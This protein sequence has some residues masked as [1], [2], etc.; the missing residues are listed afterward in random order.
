MAYD[1]AAFDGWQSQ[2]SGRT[3]QDHLEAAIS[4]VT[5]QRIRTHAAGRT[6]TGVHALGQA[7]H[8]DVPELMSADKWIAALNGNLP[9]TIRVVRSRQV[10]T[11]FHAR[12]SSLG[13][14]YRYRIWNS[15]WMHPLELGRA[16][17]VAGTVDMATLSAVTQK[18][19][20]HHDFHAFSANRGGPPENS[21]RTL[22]AIRLRK[23]GPLITLEIDGDGFLYKMV[24]LIVGSAI[25]V[26]AGRSP[27][28]WLE[29]LLT[30]PRERRSNR[31]APAEGLYLLKVRYK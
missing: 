20:G 21:E 9:S 31:C 3:V 25:H 10:P 4:T 12:F 23:R 2:P 24:R 5:G 13:K 22:H 29:R 11:D 27:I 15:A 28:D 8:V 16:W 1:G 30:H 17:H 19:E 26:A 18:L 7:V 14:T 6:D